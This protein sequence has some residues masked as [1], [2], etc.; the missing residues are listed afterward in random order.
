M[1]SSWVVSYHPLQM[2]HI[3]LNPIYPEAFI[4]DSNFAKIES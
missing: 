4:A 3:G 2:W 1:D